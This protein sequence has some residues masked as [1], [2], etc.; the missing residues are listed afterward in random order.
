MY[1]G[2]KDRKQRQITSVQ[3]RDVLAFAVRDGIQ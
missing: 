1:G 2:E 3:V